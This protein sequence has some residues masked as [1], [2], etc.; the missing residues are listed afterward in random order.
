VVG[1][2]VE[3]VMGVGLVA[4]MGREVL[5][6]AEAAKGYVEESMVL[7]FF[8]SFS[9]PNKV[10]SHPL[11]PSIIFVQLIHTSPS[12]TLISSSSSRHRRH[13][14]RSRHRSSSMVLQ[15]PEVRMQRIWPGLARL[16]L[17]L[18]LPTVFSFLE[19]PL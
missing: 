13:R 15:G 2:K 18:S 14:H 8:L 1:P 17:S 4:A 5:E 6:A 7:S 19:E 11:L 3:V 9:P 16:S 12:P 10:Q